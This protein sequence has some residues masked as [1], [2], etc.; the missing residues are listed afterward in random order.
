MS[1]HE[2]RGRI[3]VDTDGNW[4]L[5]AP[6]LPAGAEALGTV[7]RDGIDTGALVRFS[8]TGRYAQINGMAVRNLDGR[9]VGGALGSQGRQSAL[10]GGRRVQ[11]Y[12]D[13]ASL[14]AASRIGDGN[15]SDG[16]RRALA[17]AA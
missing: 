12:L 7:T 3:T 17:Q 1:N 10:V 14:E 9:K 6:N 13:D 16:I 8:A 2:N 11:V 4:R 5:Y 15:V